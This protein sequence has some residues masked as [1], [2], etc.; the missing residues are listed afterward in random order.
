[1]KLKHVEIHKYKSISESQNFDLE[2]DITVLVG[3]NESGK[4]SALEAIAKTNYFQNDEAFRF[5]VTHD[6][7]RREKKKMDKEGVDA[8]AIT[9][10]YELDDSLVSKI[11]SDLGNGII[12]TRV[13]V[14]TTHYSGK[15]TL[16]SS[17]I[18]KTKFIEGKTTQLGISSKSLNDRLSKVNTPAEFS[19]L[20]G[21]YSDQK[22]LEAITK[23]EK[24]FANTCKWNGDAINEYVARIYLMPNRPK[25]LYYDEYFSLPSRIS[26]EKLKNDELDES[27]Y[28]TAKAL[29]ELA[30]IDTD[31]LLAAD[32][33]EDYIA[34]LEATEAI[35]SGE[36]F[37]YWKTNKNLNITFAIDKRQE[38]VHN[39]TRIVEHILDIRVKSKGVSL[40]LKNRSKGFNWFFSFLVWFKKI[41]EDPNSN[42]ILLLDEPGLNLHA[43]AQ[44]DLLD[45]LEDLSDNYQI[46]YSTH[47]PFMITSGKLNRVRTVL[48][49]DNGS[50]IS[51]SVQ[52]KDPNTLFPLQAALGY[53]IAQNLFV[54]QKNLL[55]EGVSDL[56]ILTAMSGMLESAGRKFLNPDITIVPTGGLEKVAT[57]ISLLRGSKLE[58]A[59]L[60]DSFTDPKGKAKM[61]K[62]I[63][64]KIIQKGKVRFFDEYLTGY[65]KADMEDL[66]SKEDYLK[67]FNSAFKEYIDVKET[68]LLPTVQ[69]IILQ[70]N[71]FFSIQRF[72]HYRPANELVKT[73]PDIASFSDYTVDNFEK[74]FDEM[75][76][77]FSK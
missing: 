34:E 68:D 23:L 61:D 5:N 39:G 66:F 42:Y 72:N 45:F 9:C 48:E 22:Y 65:A 56:I 37:K 41:Q 19:A 53:D 16:Q 58:I 14:V 43:S 46:V 32:D 4:T 74:V 31:E 52:E 60:L 50:V 73:S 69:Q 10:T 36:L 18:D 38:D 62:L 30:D 12:K 2:D 20:K 28:K 17:I 57:F 63:Q 26:I 35:I 70:L 6:Y 29:F 1:M 77:L 49:T 3:M 33:F 25:F 21:E 67:L 75:N 40:P 15:C 13:W 8:A 54:S 47:S 71:Q 59:C 64:D 76:K 51:D 7:P 44:A 11:E 27:R 24:Y 55:V